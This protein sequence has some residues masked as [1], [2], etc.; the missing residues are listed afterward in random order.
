MTNRP[1]GRQPF[2]TA[3]GEALLNHEAQY[4]IWT[5]IKALR[6]YGDRRSALWYGVR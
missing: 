4:L 5:A 2:R 1:E 3:V 6:P